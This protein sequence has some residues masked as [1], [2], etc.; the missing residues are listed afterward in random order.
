M[1]ASTHPP[2]SKHY[3]QSLGAYLSDLTGTQ[4]GL[5]VYQYKHEG[6]RLPERTA[7]IVNP[8]VLEAQ[9]DQGCPLTVAET[10][11]IES[12]GTFRRFSPHASTQIH[13]EKVLALQQASTMESL[14][15]SNIIAQYLE[16]HMKAIID[17]LGTNSNF[18]A[19]TL[20]VAEEF[21]RTVAGKR[22]PMLRNALYIFTAR[23][24][25]RTYWVQPN[26]ESGDYAVAWMDAPWRALP[27]P[28]PKSL[29]D[30]EALNAILK[31]HLSVL[32]RFVLN[33]FT[34]KVYERKKENWFELF[35]VTFIFQVILSENLEMSFY[36]QIEAS[37][38]GTVL[39]FLLSGSPGDTSANS[40]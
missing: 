25:R 14:R 1:L 21:S 33:D 2:G 4:F 8:T 22:K 13:Q 15:H 17:T 34:A 20:R 6:D 38:C 37:V 26:T 30:A 24:L 40:Y 19:R 7:S 32:E 35:L 11:I 10:F 18:I 16:L 39:S 29:T 5:F 12:Y 36:S 28:T 3:H 27:A 23:F 31:S 9:L